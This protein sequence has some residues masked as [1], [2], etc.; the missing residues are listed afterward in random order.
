[1]LIELVARGAKTELVLTHE[2]L[3]ED[4]VESHRGGWTELTDA[5]AARVT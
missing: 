4:S 3:T 5:L 1:V 2:G